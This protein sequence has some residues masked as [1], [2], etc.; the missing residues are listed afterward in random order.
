MREPNL[1]SIKKNI[2]TFVV[3]SRFEEVFNLMIEHANKL[4]ISPKE[5][6][7]L[8]ADYLNLKKKE[9][10]N[11]ITDAEVRTNESKLRDTILDYISDNKS[12]DILLHQHNKRDI[13]QP[14]K[15][16]QKSWNQT[17]IILLAIFT[18]LIVSIFFS[19]NTGLN[20][21]SGF[22]PEIKKSN[23]IDITDIIEY[24]RQEDISYDGKQKVKT[25]FIKKYMDKCS[26]KPRAIIEGEH[27]YTDEP[28]LGEFLDRII[29]GEYKNATV[30]EVKSDTIFIK[31]E[32]LI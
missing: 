18:L 13:N 7:L 19:Q 20:L 30:R 15:H 25:E 23:E 1:E 27:T 2:E 26:C 5:V 21:S 16:N 6:K 3:S 8:Q 22:T 24:L 10:M 14:R 29:L 31:K 32:P 9:R 12:Q 4:D 28:D 17:I 11:L